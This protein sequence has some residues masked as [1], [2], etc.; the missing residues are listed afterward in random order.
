MVRS[1]YRV[2][3][4]GAT[5][6]GVGHPGT[7]PAPFENEIT[8]SHAAALSL[9]PNTELVAVCDLVPE[10]LEDFETVW[11]REWPDASTY[12][13]YR[14][15]LARER[16]DIIGVAT[17]DHRHADIVVDAAAADVKGVMCEKPLATTL[18]DADR[19]IGACAERGIPIHVN[20]TRRWN[21]LMHKVRDEV[22]A[23]LIGP[24]NTILAYHGGTRA[25]MFR[26]G[27]HIIDAVCFFAESEPVQVFA[28]LED[29][30][31]HWDRY[32]GD[33][34][35][36]PENDPGA[37]GTILFRNGITALYNCSKG[38]SAVS[39]MVHLLGSKGEIR[40][41]MNGFD[42][43]AITELEGSRESVSRT[44]HANPYQVQS[45]PAAYAE[46]IGVIEDGGEGVSTAAEARKTL[47]IL[48]GF[49]KSQQ[50]G[51]RLVDVPG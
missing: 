12:T 5:G 43:S 47:Q 23:G 8:T 41:G 20:H 11:A 49:L 35:K 30:F 7:S 45:L 13:D 28:R 34:G 42:A 39:H 1:S 31:E 48:L 26:N 38:T 9:L 46:L 17:S 50:E 14:E 4:V 21:P 18:E 33:G 24:L 2:G 19:M 44:L 29:G 32:R 40:V 27:T 36:L 15:M 37:T 10:L 25:M 51:G 6:I 3:L 22:R 16:L